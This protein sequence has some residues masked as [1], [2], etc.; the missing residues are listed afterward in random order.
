MGGEVECWS[1]IKT[2]FSG[3]ESSPGLVCWC[4]ESSAV[5]EWI[6]CVI[7]AQRFLSSISSPGQDIVL[8]SGV[9]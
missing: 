4:E 9:N 8:V 1:E 3:W 5:V 6:L 7:H 2:I